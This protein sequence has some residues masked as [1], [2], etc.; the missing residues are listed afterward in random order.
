MSGK[1]E[2]S[3]ESFACLDSRFLPRID[4][5]RLGSLLLVANDI[6]PLKE[7]P[8]DDSPYFNNDSFVLSRVWIVEPVLFL[9]FG[10]CLNV[11][12]MYNQYYSS[13]T[14][15]IL[16]YT[17]DNTRY[18]VASNQ[19]NEAFNYLFHSN[20]YIFYTYISFILLVIFPL[21]IFFSPRLERERATDSSIRDLALS[22]R[23]C[24]L[25]R[26]ETASNLSR[27]T[28]QTCPRPRRLASNAVVLIPRW[29]FY[30][31]RKFDDPNANTR[32]PP[33]VWDWKYA[34]GNI[35]EAAA[36]LQTRSFTISATGKAAYFRPS[37][38]LVM[39]L[40][41]VAHNV[42]AVIPFSQPPVALSLFFF[43]RSGEG[44]NFEI[45][46]GWCYSCL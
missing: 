11:Q 1:E 36:E 3:C 37:P 41:R 19:N 23:P 42:P 2:G 7:H 38:S 39:L 17:W 22:P 12:Y 26:A 6:V 27:I 44:E 16:Y 14:I 5:T 15:V 20:M 9:E 32:A 40:K 33:R 30:R 35:A 21:P 31:A 43:H 46:S 24:I 28:S 8:L 45:V 4:H 10:K 13:I 18:H 29:D 34:R 25:S